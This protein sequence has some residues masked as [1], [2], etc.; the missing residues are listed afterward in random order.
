MAAKELSERY[1]VEM[2]IVEGVYSV[3]YGNMDPKE[4]VVKLLNRR[5]TRE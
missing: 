1:N 4:A 2:P 3:I 5:L